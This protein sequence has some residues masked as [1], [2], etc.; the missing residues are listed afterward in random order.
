MILYRNIKAIFKNKLV[1]VDIE[2]YSRGGLLSPTLEIIIYQGKRY[3]PKHTVKPQLTIEGLFD[4]CYGHILKNM[5]PDSS[6]MSLIK[7]DENYSSSYH[8][9]VVLGVE[10]GVVFE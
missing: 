10:H 8:I 5:I 1:K 7:K 3:L 9:P 2:S 4:K 6:F